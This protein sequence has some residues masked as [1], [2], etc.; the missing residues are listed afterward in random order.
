LIAFPAELQPLPPG[1]LF[2][3]ADFAPTCDHGALAAVT[4]RLVRRAVPLRREF[5]KCVVFTR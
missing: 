2:E 5:F 4:A 3:V 1:T